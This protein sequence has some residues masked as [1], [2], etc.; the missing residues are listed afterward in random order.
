MLPCSS[1]TYRSNSLHSTS[2]KPSIQTLLWA[3]FTYWIHPH[4]LYNSLYI[5]S[6]HDLSFCVYVY[7]LGP[8]TF[9]ENETIAKYEIMDGAPVRGKLWIVVVN[10]NTAVCYSLCCSYKITIMI[11]KWTELYVYK[12]CAYSASFSWVGLIY[13]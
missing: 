6:M 3:T 11:T 8:N 10:D 12:H 1:R 2:N 7:I 13:Y 9:N 4:T 5:I